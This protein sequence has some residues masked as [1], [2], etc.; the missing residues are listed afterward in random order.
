[1]LVKRMKEKGI[2]L[3][4]T[5]LVRN[6]RG[7]LGVLITAYSVREGKYS[8]W[9]NIESI[10]RNRKRMYRLYRHLLRDFATPLGS[11]LIDEFI[12]DVWELAN[13]LLIKEERNELAV[14]T[15]TPSVNFA[16]RRKAQF[17]TDEHWSL[18]S[19]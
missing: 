5:R 17:E 10:R 16:G 15:K 4:G 19:I 9:V 8:F 7:Y 13:Q 11:E 14:K 3:F 12:D 2:T 1:M 6:N 18:Q